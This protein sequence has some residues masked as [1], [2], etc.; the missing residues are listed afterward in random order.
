M[1]RIGFAAI[2]IFG[3]M[4]SATAMTG[5]QLLQSCESLLREVKVSP[6][7]RVRVPY[8][9]LPCWNYMQAIQD[10]SVVADE[11]GRPLLRICAPAES[12]LMQYIRIFADH[13]RRNPAKLHESGAW[14]AQGALATAFPCR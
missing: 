12:T 10:A 9:G 6:D 13:A 5:E 3:L 11:S 1:K 7:G 14:I 2:A 8:E 4:T